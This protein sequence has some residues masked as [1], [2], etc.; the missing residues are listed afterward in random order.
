M[1]W[2]WPIYSFVQLENNYWLNIKY[3]STRTN[4]YRIETSQKDVMLFW[5][6][7]YWWAQLAQRVSRLPICDFLQFTASKVQWTL[8]TTNPLYNVSLDT[9]YLRNGHHPDEINWNRVVYNESPDKTNR[10]LGYK[11]VCCIQSSLYRPS[12]MIQTYIIR[13]FLWSGLVSGVCAAYHPCHQ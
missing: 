13:M 5:K 11:R 10:L 6:Q 2:A 7:H 4:T 8:H 12:S 3:I 1:V 9:K